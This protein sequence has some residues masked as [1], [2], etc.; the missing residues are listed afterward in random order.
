MIAFGVQEHRIRSL[1][2]RLDDAKLGDL[3]KERAA[4]T[5]D[6]EALGR[7]RAALATTIDGLR[8]QSAA[9]EARLAGINAE[10]GRTEAAGRK[11]VEMG[12]VDET[13]AALRAAGLRSARPAR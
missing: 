7:D 1:H 10:L 11:L 13:V 4:V 9:L 2:A 12:T 6:R 8:R 5:A 3:A